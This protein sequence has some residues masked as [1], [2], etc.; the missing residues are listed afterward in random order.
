MHHSLSSLLDLFDFLLL[1][2]LP[3][4]RLLQLQSVFL[5]GN[6]LHNKVNVIALLQILVCPRVMFI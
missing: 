5:Q 2:P 1:I 3:Y 4:I 6:L